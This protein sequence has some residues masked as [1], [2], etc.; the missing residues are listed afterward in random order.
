MTEKECL[1]EFLDFL[2]E[3][4]WEMCQSKNDF[5]DILEMIQN[6]E[7]EL[8]NKLEKLEEN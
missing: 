1:N 7:E 5:N 4:E 2:E 6:K 8:E 3:V